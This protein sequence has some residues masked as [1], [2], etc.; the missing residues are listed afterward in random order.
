M[1]PFAEC[2]VVI[3]CNSIEDFP[4][5]LSSDAARSLLGGLTAAWHPRLIAATGK[6]PAWYRADEL[7]APVRAVRSDDQDVFSQPAS[8]RSEAKYRLIIVPQASLTEIASE[9]RDCLVAESHGV[10]DRELEAHGDENFLNDVVIEV[11][12]RADAVRKIAAACEAL[13]YRSDDQNFWNT[14]S[15]SFGRS[16]Q[17]DIGASDFYALGYTWWQIQVLTRRLRYTS[18]LD[19]QHFENRLA[20]AASKLGAGDTDAA[21][22][23]LHDCYDALAEE[24]DHYFS[25]DPAILDLALVT[26]G[27]LNDWLQSTE[28][29]NGDVQLESTAGQSVPLATPQNVLVDEDVARAIQELP[30]EAANVARQSL[31]RSDIGIC[32]GGP[33][34]D[35]CVQRLSIGQVEDRVA[36]ALA[37]VKETLGQ[38][39]T[40]YARLGGGIAADWLPAILAAKFQGV[41]PIDFIN[42]VGFGEESKVILGDSGDETEALTAKPIDA[43]DDSAFLTLSALMGEAIDGGEI[44]TSLLVHWPGQGCDSFHD[45][46]RASTWTLALGKFW[47]ID[48]YFSEGERPYHHGSLPTPTVQTDLLVDPSDTTL[49]STFAGQTQ[50]NL[51][52][53]LALIDPDAATDSRNSTVDELRRK[54]A[55]SLGYQTI[56][57]KDAAAGSVV[58]IHPHSPP[59]RQRISIAGKIAAHASSVFHA[60][61]EGGQTQVIADVPAWGFAV[62]GEV[63]KSAVVEPSDDDPNFIQK[64]G[65]WLRPRIRKIVDG[66]RLSNEFMDVSLNREHGGVDGVYSGRGRGNRFSTRLIVTPVSAKQSVVAVCDRVETITNT[67]TLGEIAMS[68]RFVDPDDESRQFPVWEARY[69]LQRGSRQLIYRVKVAGPVPDSAD[70]SAIWKHLPSLR[71]AIAESTPIIRCI[72]SEKLRRTSAR[73]FASTTGFQV[74]EADD[75][76]TLVASDRPT[77]HRRVDE[78]FLDT[79]ITASVGS[80]WHTFAFGFDVRGP[81]ASARELQSRDTIAVPI[82]ASANGSA[83]LAQRGWLMHVSPSTV[84]AQVVDIGVVSDQG[85]YLAIHF[86]VIQTAGKPAK[87]SLRFCR[88]V[89]SVIEV[90]SLSRPL[91]SSDAELTLADLE[92]HA[93][94]HGVETDDDQIKWS[95][96]AHGVVHFVVL[97]ETG[98]D[99]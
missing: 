30:A 15:D 37:I 67:T 77:I 84:E 31:Q 55:S 50:K 91:A 20:E 19:Q 41:V 35:L 42:G 96:R 79:L 99:T 21:C 97:F 43:D 29:S 27:T 83:E 87:A 51:L 76:T 6:Q 74:E 1:L 85:K 36:G 44:A 82:Q 23:A 94:S 33:S 52:G 28:N 47:K 72:N 11:A 70:D 57:C 92:S 18:N 22:A 26:P 61:A 48:E 56:A 34:S 12:D 88:G 62:I 17:R 80:D 40:V 49:S 4:S 3:P 69:Q 10:I 53:M 64:M 95:Q 39:P 86:R 60:S 66:D 54:I 7:P 46:R 13:G 14:S 81:V 45:V 63:A 59:A 89:H 65:R 93:I 58:L 5:R 90:S 24:R 68:G 32:G 9:I 8:D 38:L 71:I 75:R 25:S 16:G 98:G 73:R 78:R 2:C